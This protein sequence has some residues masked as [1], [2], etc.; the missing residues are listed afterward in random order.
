VELTGRDRQQPGSATCDCP[1]LES[2]AL[3]DQ[4]VSE[5]VLYQSRIL[6]AHVVWLGCAFKNSSGSKVPAGNQFPWS[7][8]EEV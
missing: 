7:S 8:F 5:S 4:P 3:S 6:D 2:E 1:S